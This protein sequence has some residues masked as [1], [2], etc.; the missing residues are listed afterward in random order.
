MWKG[1]VLKYFFTFYMMKMVDRT[2]GSYHIQ[3]SYRTKEYENRL[4]FLE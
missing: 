4:S 2:H 1:I 3:A